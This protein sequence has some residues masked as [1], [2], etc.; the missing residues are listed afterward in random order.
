MELGGHGLTLGEISVGHEGGDIDLSDLGLTKCFNI[1]LKDFAVQ[2]NN[3]KKILGG[4]GHAISLGS[5]GG[6]HLGEE[7]L[8]GGHL[9]GG[10]G[11]FIPIVKSIGI[12]VAKKVPFIVPSLQVEGIPQS[13]PVPV[14]IQRPVPY[15]VERQVFSKV[16]KKVPTPIEKIIP[17]KIEKPV[18]FHIVKHI[19]VPV[20]KPIPI[21]IPI[22]KTVV[23]SSKGH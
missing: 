7:H 13:Y 20:T 11:H 17:V 23:H 16:E 21:K 19:P 15:P 5:Y 6:G 18:P 2:Y 22:Y 3:N 14:V 8:G 12:P 10:G 1:I 9:G 4:S